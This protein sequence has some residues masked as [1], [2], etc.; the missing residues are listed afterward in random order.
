MTWTWI[1]SIIVFEILT[2]YCNNDNYV[3]EILVRCIDKTR[4]H[5]LMILVGRNVHWTLDPD[6]S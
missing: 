6:S 4:R 5:N 2:H 3:M 1:I